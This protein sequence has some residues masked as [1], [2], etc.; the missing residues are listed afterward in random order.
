MWTRLR[1]RRADAV[2]QI[3]ALAEQNRRSPA[4]DTERRLLALRHEAGARLLDNAPA[5]PEFAQPDFD[6]LPVETPLP[7]F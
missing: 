5:E 4:R 3:D 6:R 7:E 1:P 2:E